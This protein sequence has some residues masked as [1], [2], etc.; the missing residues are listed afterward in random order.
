[1]N[2]ELEY[3]DY[4]DTFGLP[5]CPRYNNRLKRA[6]NVEGSRLM[7]ICMK[8]HNEHYAELTEM[9]DKGLRNLYRIKK[10]R[11]DDRSRMEAV[12]SEVTD[13]GLNIPSTDFDWYVVELESQKACRKL[14]EEIL[15]EASVYSRN[16]PDNEKQS[17]V[18]VDIDD[19]D[20]IQI[21]ISHWEKD[22]VEDF[23]ELEATPIEET[24]YTRDTWF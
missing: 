8:C 11:N 3:V 6:D 19:N 4:D 22:R 16:H 17:K 20:I 18:S 10:K 15:P 24:E 9:S 2:D 1:M 21:L 12:E 5:H 23:F 13:R 7:Y 14:T